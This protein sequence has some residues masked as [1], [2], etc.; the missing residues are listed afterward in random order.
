MPHKLT[1][2]ES[3]QQQGRKR[4]KETNQVYQWYHDLSSLLRRWRL[5]RELR[6]WGQQDHHCIEAYYQTFFIMYFKGKKKR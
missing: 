1:N 4:L 3:I 5:N 6:W 2:R